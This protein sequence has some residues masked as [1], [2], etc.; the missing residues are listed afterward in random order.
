LQWELRIEDKKIPLRMFDYAGENLTDLFS[1]KKDEATGAAM[2]FFEKVRT[3]FENASVLL[4]LIN[5]ETFIVKDAASA[6]EHKDTLIRAISSFLEKRKHKGRS[7]RVCFVFTAYD[8]F[9]SVILSKY[10]SVMKFLDQEIPPL[11]Y[12]ILDEQ[13][14]V[15]VLEVA[16]VGETEHRV[17]PHD[18]R[19]ILSPKPGFQTQGFEKLVKWL[20]EAVGET[21]VELD[22]KAEEA[23]QDQHNVKFLE[24]LAN[25]WG[26]VSRA[27]Q[28]EPV[29]RFIEA[30]QDNFPYPERPNAAQLESQ[31]ILYLN[32]ASDLKAKIEERMRTQTIQMISNGVKNVLGLLAIIVL[33]WI[34]FK[35]IGRAY[36]NHKQTEIVRLRAPQPEVNGKW[37]WKYTCDGGLFDCWTHRATATVPVKNNGGAGNVT[38]TFKVGNTSI[39][40]KQFFN[41]GEFVNVVVEIP[42]LPNHNENEGNITFNASK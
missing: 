1:G 12:A 34:V 29:K 19:T 25:E 14:K 16:A 28:L 24:N 32:S 22:S 10:G 41:D 8:Q 33:I 39:S 11:Y 6:S 21:K 20:V 3:I 37:N 17:N 7:S 9:K 31:K 30:A 26:E 23:A 42:N 38:I 4:V 40:K 35:F 13:S 15:E 36:E 18:G 2:E 27:D 5:L